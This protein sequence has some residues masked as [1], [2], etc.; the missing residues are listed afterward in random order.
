MTDRYLR[1]ER[2]DLGFVE[3]LTEVGLAQVAANAEELLTE[4]GYEDEETQRTD[5]RIAG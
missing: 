4:P 1:T 5:P 2:V 3:Y